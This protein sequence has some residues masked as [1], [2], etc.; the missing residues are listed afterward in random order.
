MV[1]TVALTATAPGGRWK[2]P[3]EARRAKPGYSTSTIVS[4]GIGVCQKL[5][6][7]TLFPL[8]LTGMSRAPMPTPGVEDVLENLR[9]PREGPAQTVQSSVNTRSAQS[10]D[11]AISLATLLP[12][13]WAAYE[14]NNS[15][16][17]ELWLTFAR[18]GAKATTK[19]A[20]AH[21]R[22]TSASHQ[23]Q[24]HS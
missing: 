21:E 9:Q 6:S 15:N 10:L 5:A 14:V 1:R 20:L 2:W 16:G 19:I 24:S 23:T 4:S 17:A 7:S 18:H 13:S 22:D 12:G 8:G 11:E 3:V